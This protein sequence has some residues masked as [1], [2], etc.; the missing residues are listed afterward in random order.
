M[1]V[2][3]PCLSSDDGAVECSIHQAEDLDCTSSC[4]FDP[5]MLEQAAGSPSWIV[6][7]SRTVCSDTFAR[8]VA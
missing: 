2:C 8:Q 1:F 7:G 5:Y 3:C 6:G 4:I